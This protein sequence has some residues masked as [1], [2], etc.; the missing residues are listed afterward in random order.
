MASLG[1]ELKRERELRAVSLKDIADETKILKRYLQAL[2]DDKPELLPGQFF[3]K[4][5][6]RAYS[7]CIGLDENYFVNKYH[8]VILMKS[9]AEESNRKSLL[10]APLERP[11]PRSKAARFAAAAAILLV[12]VGILTAVYAFI[13]RPAKDNRPEIKGSAT[14]TAEP[15]RL[16][17]PVVPPDAEVKP[18]APETGLLLELAFTADTWIRL[19]A[20]GQV[21]LDGIKK[22]GERATCRAKEEFVIQIGNAGGL[23]YTLNGRPGKPFGAPGAVMTNIRINRETLAGYQTAPGDKT[24]P[25]KMR[26]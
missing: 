24:P 7:K 16:A 12:V 1:Q 15:I 5:V 21:Q 4:S 26:P 11:R 9:E 20:D 3:I 2:E 14:V 23:T 6:L 22:P 13:I 19:A 8:E 25:G 18:Q 17:P 10:A